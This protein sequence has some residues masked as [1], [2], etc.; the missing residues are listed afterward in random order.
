MN[1]LEKQTLKGL[2][3][4]SCSSLLLVPLREPNMN[5]GNLKEPKDPS[6]TKQNPEMML[7]GTLKILPPTLL[8]KPSGETDRLWPRV[9]RPSAQESIV[10]RPRAKHEHLQSQGS[11]GSIHDKTESCDDA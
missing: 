11:I 7:R 3:Q 4:P 8:L 10:L 1:P 9:N 5:T 6:M 2:P